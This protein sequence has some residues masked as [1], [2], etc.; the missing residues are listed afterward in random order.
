MYAFF[1][2]ENL[3]IGLRMNVFSV[4]M[5]KHEAFPAIHLSEASLANVYW[6]STKTRV[7]DAYLRKR[8][9]DLTSLFPLSLSPEGDE[10]SHP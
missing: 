5:E 4:T 8:K 3:Q 7:A 1:A 10:M 6:L 2:N 9:L